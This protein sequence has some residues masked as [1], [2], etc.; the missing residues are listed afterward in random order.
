MFF[1][2]HLNLFIKNPETSGNNYGKIIHGA[3][4]KKTETHHFW[5]QIVNP[6]SFHAFPRRRPPVTAESSAARR[7]AMHDSRV[8][9]P[10]PRG[11]G[12]GGNCGKNGLQLLIS[13][14]SHIF[15]QIHCSCYYIHIDSTLYF[16]YIQY[17]Y[18]YT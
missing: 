16:I 7:Q 17:I 6:E 5:L 10:S 3:L 13:I 4:R 11:G 15:I 8:K 9:F 14:Y 2:L 18:I 1:S 12:D